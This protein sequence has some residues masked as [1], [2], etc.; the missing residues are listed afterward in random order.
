MAA[1]R[2]V[3]LKYLGDVDDPKYLDGRTGDNTVGLVLSTDG[4]SKT[5]WVESLPAPPVP[6]I[7]P[8]PP[9]TPDP[10]HVPRTIPVPAPDPPDPPERR[11]RDPGN[12][13]NPLPAPA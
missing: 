13:I 8:S 1:L 9:G 6:E 5:R 7:P 10:S 4:F 11:R 2:I 12:P 3:T